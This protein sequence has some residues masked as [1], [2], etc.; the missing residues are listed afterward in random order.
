MK[1]KI[2]WEIQVVKFRLGNDLHLLSPC[3]TTTSRS[4]FMAVLLVMKS[5]TCSMTSWGRFLARKWRTKQSEAF[6]SRFCR[7][8]AWIFLI[9]TN[10]GKKNLIGVEFQTISIPGQVWDDHSCK[11]V[12]KANDGQTNEE[13]PPH[14]EDKDKVAPMLM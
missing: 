4:F 1:W 9:R 13:H 5:I 14:P 10:L 2:C 3:L 12:D 7:W 8:H 6:R 11:S